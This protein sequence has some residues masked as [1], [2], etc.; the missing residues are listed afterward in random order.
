MVQPGP[1]RHAHCHAPGGV[2]GRGHQ[3]SPEPE[4]VAPIVVALIG[5]RLPSGRY[6][7]AELIATLAERAGSQ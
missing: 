4:T 5:S 1:R 6:R 7:A 3:R 2:S